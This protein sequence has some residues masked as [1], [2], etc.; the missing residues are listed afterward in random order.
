MS[1]YKT[2]EKL[3]LTSEIDDRI[4][5]EQVLLLGVEDCKVELN[6]MVVDCCEHCDFVVEKVHIEVSVQISADELHL[7]RYCIDVA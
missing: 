1:L 7:Y 6:S 5:T 4:L 3:V 2:I